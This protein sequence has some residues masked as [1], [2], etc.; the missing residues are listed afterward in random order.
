MPFTAEVKIPVPG[1]VLGS[2]I[3]IVPSSNPSLITVETPKVGALVGGRFIT[4]TCSSLAKILLARLMSLSGFIIL[5]A[6]VP[7]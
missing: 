6:I 3:V 4:V 7:V 2:V 1:V 5:V